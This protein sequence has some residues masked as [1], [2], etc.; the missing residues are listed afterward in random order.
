MAEQA[1]PEA[2]SPQGESS[3]KPVQSDDAAKV[4]KENEAKVKR[5]RELRE[6]VIA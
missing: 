6:K 1:V 3:K 2:L 4:K 5:L